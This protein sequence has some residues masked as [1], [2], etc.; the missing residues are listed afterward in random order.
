MGLASRV[1]SRLGFGTGALATTAVVLGGFAVVTGDVSLTTLAGGLSSGDDSAEATDVSNTLTSQT[2]VRPTKPAFASD[3]AALSDSASNA[4][5]TGPTTIP[6]PSSTTSTAQHP[7]PASP[8]IA[9]RTT[10][11]S[12]S[13]TVTSVSVTDYARQVLNQ[14][15]AAREAEDLPALTMRSGLVRSAWKHNKA[16]SAG[17]GLSH[18]CSSEPDLGQRISA[19]DV[20]WTS[21]GENVGQGGPEPDNGEAIVAMAQQLTADMLAE[22]PPNDG[23]RKNILNKSFKYV[24]ISLYR[25]D[26]GT[27]WMTQDFAG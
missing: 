5:L 12:P 8:S 18:Q 2:G 4:P 23:H 13:P 14:M 17:C 6:L 22:T 24:G 19:E 7:T 1:L 26:N 25:D 20:T 27:V 10:T 15:N 21:A 3:D 11:R 16:M 9:T